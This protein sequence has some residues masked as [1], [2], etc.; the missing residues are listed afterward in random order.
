MILNKDPHIRAALLFGR[1]KFNP[2]VLVEPK[3]EYAFDPTDLVKVA[4]FRNKIWYAL[5]VLYI[6]KGL[7]H[8]NI[9]ISG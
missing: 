9:T 4:Q 3:P 1:G 7:S 2:G 6:L 5:V 8:L